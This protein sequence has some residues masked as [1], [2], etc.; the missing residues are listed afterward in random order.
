MRMKNKTRV[1]RSHSEPQRNNNNNN[2]LLYS[3][4]GTVNYMA[5]E[6]LTHR[7]FHTQTNTQTQIK[8]NSKN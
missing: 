5:P 2:N 4:I 7:L 6:M 3:I 1:Y 8:K